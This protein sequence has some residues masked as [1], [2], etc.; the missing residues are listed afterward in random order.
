MDRLEGWAASVAERMIRRACRRL[1][2]GEREL[3]ILEWTAELPAIL[4]DP[5][6]HFRLGRVARVLAYAADNIRGVRSLLPRGRALGRVSRW[7][8]G[9]KKLVD[10]RVWRV[11]QSLLVLNASV[12]ITIAY[13]DQK[14]ALLPAI[15]SVVGAV[16][17]MQWTYRVARQQRRRLRNGMAGQHEQG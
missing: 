17:T 12:A 2:E 15:A 10:A 3:R 11:G 4:T 8:S 1:P 13:F 5:S 6:R 9:I 16:A 14:W 7:R